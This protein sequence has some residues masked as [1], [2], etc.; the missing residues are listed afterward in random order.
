MNR[1]Y[2]QTP[3]SGDV[4]QTIVSLNKEESYHACKVLRLKENQSVE[5]ADGINR[6]SGTIVECKA[7]ETTVKLLEL[8]PSTE[9]QAKLVLWQGLP[10][11]DKLEWIIQKA[12]ELGVYEIWPVAMQRSVSKIDKAEKAQKKGERYQRI[13]LEA[14]KQ[15]GRCVVPTVEKIVDLQ[16]ALKRCK[17]FDAIFIAWEEEKTVLLSQA[18]KNCNLINLES[19]K[20]LLIIGPEG[21]ISASEKDAISTSLLNKAVAVSLGKRILRTETAGISAISAL[22][23]LLNEL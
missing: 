22:W 21:G 7:D 17:D 19:P 13:A 10:K 1:F 11:G 15:S 18:V 14:S 12:T 6:Y 4:L 3:L 8:L 2:L 23:A 5:I 20:I 9:T 16:T